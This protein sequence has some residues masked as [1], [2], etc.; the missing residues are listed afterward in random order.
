MISPDPVFHNIATAAQ[1][2]QRA[3][4]W[5]TKADLVLTIGSNGCYPY[6]GDARIIDINLARDGFTQEASLCL[7]MTAD[8]ALTNLDRLLQHYD[9]VQ[10]S[11]QGTSNSHFGS[12]FI[13]LRVY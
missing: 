3:N 7:K 8:Q 4:A 2:I 12:L 6:T 13:C 5:M 10:N 1:A 11:F 9:L